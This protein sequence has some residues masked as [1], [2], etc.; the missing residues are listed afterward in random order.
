[1][2][3]IYL[4]LSCLFSFSISLADELNIHSPCFHDKNTIE[5]LVSEQKYLS[6]HFQITELSNSNSRPQPIEINE[7]RLKMLYTMQTIMP[8][9]MKVFTDMAIIYDQPMD[10]EIFS[11]SLTKD[12][13]ANK[14]MACL[15]AF[16]P[17]LTEMAYEAPNSY[18]VFITM[19]KID[20]V[21][22]CEL[23]IYFRS[24]ATIKVQSK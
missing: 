9:V 14:D 5:C 10:L 16:L 8:T 24:M 4:L 17:S 2:K 13:I 3:K 20:K 6:E 15:K 21:K 1:M 18:D 19:A 11:I 22:P 7:E 23:D 12:V